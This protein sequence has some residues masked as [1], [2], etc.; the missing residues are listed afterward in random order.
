MWQRGNHF[1]VRKF[2]L[3]MIFSSNVENPLI[4]F[5]FS[6]EDIKAAG[7]FVLF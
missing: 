1:F 5:Y 4:R 6:S 7:F 3:T 2:G